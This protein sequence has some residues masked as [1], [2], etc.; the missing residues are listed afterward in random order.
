MAQ[1]EFK[2]EEDDRKDWNGVKKIASDINLIF[3]KLQVF[4]IFMNKI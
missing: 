3:F 4:R 2:N 1:A